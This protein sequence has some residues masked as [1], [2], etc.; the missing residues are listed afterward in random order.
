MS[1]IDETAGT[2]T[3]LLEPDDE[4]TD[5]VDGCP[6]HVS[7]CVYCEG[8]CNVSCTWNSLEARYVPMTCCTAVSYLW[9][10]TNV[11]FSNSSQFGKRCTHL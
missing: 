6:R 9:I 4:H 11:I 8:D 10:E 5:N 2:A 1:E 3:S 7:E